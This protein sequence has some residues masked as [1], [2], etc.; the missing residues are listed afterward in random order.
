MRLV[1][2]MVFLVSVSCEQQIENTTPIIGSWQMNLE[3]YSGDE[4]LSSLTGTIVFQATELAYISNTGNIDEPIDYKW[5]LDHGVLKLKNIDSG[6]AI[7]Y[8]LETITPDRAVFT[9]D[10]SIKLSLNRN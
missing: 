4:H 1:W 7:I 3:M 8:Q 2:I 5:S 6:I 9:N 10:R